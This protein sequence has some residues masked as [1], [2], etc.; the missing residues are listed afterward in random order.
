[1][2]LLLGQ[3]RVLSGYVPQKTVEKRQK[4]LK[5]DKDSLMGDREALNGNGEALKGYGVAFNGRQG[6][7]RWQAETLK[8]DKEVPLKNRWNC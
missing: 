4:G 8:S 7:V 1:M 2:T 3:Y 5:V 6:D